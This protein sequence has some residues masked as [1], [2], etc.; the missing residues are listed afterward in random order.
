[1]CYHRDLRTYHEAKC[2]IIRR[3]IGYCCTYK[4]RKGLNCVIVRTGDTDIMV[5]SI[6]AVVRL[7][8]LT[9]PCI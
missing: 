6:A 8:N 7:E 9:L 4:H 3:Q 1:M 5:V 2:A